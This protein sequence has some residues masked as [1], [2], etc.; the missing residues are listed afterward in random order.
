MSHAAARSPEDSREGVKTHVMSRYCG[1]NSLAPRALT[2]GVK[3]TGMLSSGIKSHIGLP[4]GSLLLPLPVSLPLSVCLLMR[5]TEAAPGTG[6]PPW[7]DA[8]RA[9]SVQ[10]GVHLHSHRPVTSACP[11]HLCHRLPAGAQKPRTA[12]GLLR[13]PGWFCVETRGCDPV[14]VLMPWWLLSTTGCAGVAQ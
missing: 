14:W 3:D 5:G 2:A 7:E 1:Q 4:V 8:A 9:R 13:V 11:T 10:P 6:E 12:V